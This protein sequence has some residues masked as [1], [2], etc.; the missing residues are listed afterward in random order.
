MKPKRLTGGYQI[1]VPA[2]L[3]KFADLKEQAIGNPILPAELQVQDDCDHRSD[4]SLC[5]PKTG[6]EAADNLPLL[7]NA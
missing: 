5:N 4:T 7:K 3:L 1:S 2:D 6:P